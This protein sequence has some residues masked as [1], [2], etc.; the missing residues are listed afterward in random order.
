MTC[1]QNRRSFYTLKKTCSVPDETLKSI[2]ERSV[3]HSPSAFNAQQSRA[4]IVTSAMHDQLWD[5]VIETYNK[6]FKD[7]GASL[8]FATGW[9]L[10]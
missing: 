6:L 1:Q 8:S 9:V 10:F 2:V 3:L 7:N 4:I 5:M